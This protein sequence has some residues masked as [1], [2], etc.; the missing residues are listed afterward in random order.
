MNARNVPIVVTELESNSRDA[1]IANGYVF[2]EEELDKSYEPT[3]DE[4][5]EYAAYL[6]MDL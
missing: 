4:I 5:Q 6:G 2:L 1:L 3:S